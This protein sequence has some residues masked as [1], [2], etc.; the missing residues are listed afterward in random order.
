MHSFMLVFQ[1]PLLIVFVLMGSCFS[2]PDS[3]E[4]RSY[5]PRR[6]Q[7]SGHKL[8]G[9]GGQRLGGARVQQAGG[10]NWTTGDQSRRAGTEPVSFLFDHFFR[11]VWTNCTKF[12]LGRASQDDGGS[13]AET[14]GGL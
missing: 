8:G 12:P 6:N 9:G 1:L 4:D 7:Q 5:D 10:N 14:Y 11:F 13:G 2:I 3:D